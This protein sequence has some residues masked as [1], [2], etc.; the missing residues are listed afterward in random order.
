MDNITPGKVRVE[1][2]RNNLRTSVFALSRT[3][4]SVSGEEVQWARQDGPTDPQMA[5][6]AYMVV[7][8]S[9]LNGPLFA[10]KDRLQHKPLTKATFLKLLKT[11]AKAAGYGN[12]VQ[13]HGIWISAT[14][15][16]LLRGMPFE[17]MK[18]KGR[19]AS[20]TFQMY[21]RKHNQI[22]VP[23][24]QAMSP[25]TAATFTRLTMPCVH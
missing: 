1:V 23:Y 4:S 17:V 7:N 24:I 10:Y 8:N 21:L 16:Y 25:D 22:L 13:G 15:E 18:T 9:P 19:W 3:K 2:D 6:D 11:K 12:T 5:F 14:L 20:N